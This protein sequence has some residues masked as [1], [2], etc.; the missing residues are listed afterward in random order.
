[1]YSLALALLCLTSLRSRPNSDFSVLVGDL[2]QV[3]D[4]ALVTEE[5]YLE[6]IKV[7]YTTEHR[8]IFMILSSGKNLVFQTRSRFLVY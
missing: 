5:W 8:F 3:N 6:Y 1:M 7:Q 4:N 2:C